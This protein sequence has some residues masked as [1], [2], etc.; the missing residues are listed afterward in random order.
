MQDAAVLL[1][2]FA[3]LAPV[4]ALPALLWA[5]VAGTGALERYG[6]PMAVVIAFAW[7]FRYLFWPL[8]VDRLK[9]ADENAANAQ[10]RMDEMQ[11]EFLRALER[12]DT[13]IRDILDLR[14]ARKPAKKPK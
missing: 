10:R 11:G 14:P 4:H 12:Q 9:K 2:R 6:L 1:L 3:A 13:T 8:L 7:A 5:Q